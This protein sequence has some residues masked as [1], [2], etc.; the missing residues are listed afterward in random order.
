MKPTFWRGSCWRAL[1]N[2]GRRPTF[3]ACSDTRAAR[4]AERVEEKVAIAN[5]S[6]P[7]A[8]ASEA[9][10]LVSAIGGAGY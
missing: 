2:T 8:V 5:I 9:I 3:N 7:P 6:V 1:N 10:V 4:L